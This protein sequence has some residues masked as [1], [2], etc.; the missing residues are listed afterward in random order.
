[1][2]HTLH[3]KIKKKNTLT[4]KKS[5]LQNPT[6]KNAKFVGIKSI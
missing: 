3:P 4:I 1:M 2:S 5:K 6:R